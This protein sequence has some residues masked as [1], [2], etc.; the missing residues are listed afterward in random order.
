MAATIIYRK[1]YFVMSPFYTPN[2]S[3]VAVV[4]EQDAL[5][6]PCQ[7]V[8]HQRAD[9]RLGRYRHCDEYRVQDQSSECYQNQEVLL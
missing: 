1:P 2:H 6:W 8:Q 4:V 7:D 3:V 9:P 5:G